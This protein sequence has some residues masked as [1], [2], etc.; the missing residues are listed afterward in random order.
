MNKEGN[1]FSFDEK[2]FIGTL[3]FN[4]MSYNEALEHYL[5]SKYADNDFSLF[6]NVISD[7]LRKFGYSLQSG[8][9]YFFTEEQ[10]KM[11]IYCL[12][13]GIDYRMI[14]TPD[15]TDEE[16]KNV[17]KGIDSYRNYLEFQSMLKLDASSVTGVV[18]S[19]RKGYTVT[20]YFKSNLIVASFLFL[21]EERGCYV[22]DGKG[23][24]YR[25]YDKNGDILCF[26]NVN[27][28]SLDMINLLSSYI[29]KNV[30]LVDIAQYIS[31][32]YSY[33]KVLLHR[34][35]IGANCEID[36]KLLSDLSDE[37]C[38]KIKEGL[39]KGVFSKYL[40]LLLNDGLYDDVFN[41]L[42]LGWS[43]VKCRLH[44]ALL[45]RDY[46]SDIDAINNLDDDLCKLMLESV[47]N[48]TYMD[49]YN[50][51]LYK[52][53]LSLES[54]IKLNSEDIILK[55]KKELEEERKSNRRKDLIEKY[56]NI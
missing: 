23:S 56:S 34:R 38:I 32:N 21:L 40:V 14:I 5:K 35:L 22:C 47:N 42:K 53:K 25:I 18:S 54:L 33:D 17:K 46:K 4:G 13:Y 26:F 49:C 27:K 16:L 15:I 29:M 3:K 8:G 10:I 9:K 48:D 12:A 24:V 6:C 36:I 43:E 51:T 41:Y 11:M 30:S 28:Y 45:S 2:D 52:L 7:G 39:D 55:K 44:Q 50:T 19:L 1:K 20:P 37:L 31:L